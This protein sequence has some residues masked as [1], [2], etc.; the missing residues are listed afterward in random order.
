VQY[1]NLSRQVGLNTR[2]RYTYRPGSD[3]YFVVNQGWDYDERRFQRLNTAIT[4]KI[5]AT[6]RF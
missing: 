1:D 5:G 3:L 2:L 4:T 6:V